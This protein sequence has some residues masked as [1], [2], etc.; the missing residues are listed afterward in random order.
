VSWTAVS[1]SV[2]TLLALVSAPWCDMDAYR[3]SQLNYTMLDC[4]EHLE[5]SSVL[6]VVV[7]RVIPTRIRE[8][9]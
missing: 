3:P 7:D 2:H 1:R 4:Q 5:S 6:A 9:S 8:I